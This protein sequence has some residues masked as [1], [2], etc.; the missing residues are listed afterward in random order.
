MAAQHLTNKYYRAPA[1]YLLARERAFGDGLL[2]LH[3]V[4]DRVHRSEQIA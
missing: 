4:V 1:A 2:D 3:Q